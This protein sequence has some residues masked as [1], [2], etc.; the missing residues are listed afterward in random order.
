MKHQLDPILNG[1]IATEWSDMP[2]YESKGKGNHIFIDYLKVMGS[3]VSIE[4][5]L[6]MLFTFHSYQRAL[7]DSRYKNFNQAR[8]WLEQ[9]RR[10][11]IGF[12]E[13]VQL[14]MDSLYYPASA[15]LCYANGLYEQA[16]KEMETGVKLFERI[17]E[18][19]LFEGVVS[20]RL[21]QIHNLSKVYMAM[22]EYERSAEILVDL[23]A[24]IF[25]IGSPFGFVKPGHKNGFAEHEEK[26]GIEKIDIIKY[27]FD[28]I[29]LSA[30]LHEASDAEL[31]FVNF[32]EKAKCLALDE[33]I[34]PIRTIC[35]GIN[36]AIKR[37]FY[38]LNKDYLILIT[39]LD[40][41]P[42]SIGIYFSQVLMEFAKD[43]GY[44]R[45]EELMKEFMKRYP[46]QKKTFQF[47]QKHAK[48][49]IK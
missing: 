36:N 40:V 19:Q 29:L 31:I 17:E 24:Y 11:E 35:D 49:V 30:V 12:S 9:S 6:S 5:K 3:Q 26:Q 14:V 41:L 15:Y 27:F 1:L 21:E 20:A 46:D 38:A 45:S 44:N 42:K 25:N 23:T 22:K 10:G 8:Y 47:S 13:N 2:R 7:D 39:Q 28:S 32:I 18:M 16:L 43:T 33:N 48:S 4:E 34:F 37:D